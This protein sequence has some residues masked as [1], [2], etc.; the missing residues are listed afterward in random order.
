MKNNKK[1]LDPS[2]S[3]R[4]R[5]KA[6][7][8][9]MTLEEKISQMAHLAPAIPRLG[10]PAYTWWNECLHGVGRAGLATVF[11]QSIGM[12]ATFDA[13]LEKRVATAISDEAR[14]KFNEFQRKGYTG[15]YGGLT[16]WS[17]N[18]NIFRDPRWGRGQETLGED[19][20]LA[21]RMGVAF[22]KGLQGGDRRHLKA[23]ACAK[24]FAAHS[25]PEAG[26]NAFN[27]LVSQ[28]D[29]RETYLP[30]FKALVEEGGVE[31]VMTAYNRLNGHPCSANGELL[32]GILRDEWKFDGHVVSDCGAIENIY[33]HHKTA[34]SDHTAAA[35]AV[36]A[37]CDLCCGGAYSAL[38]EAVE[39]GEIEEGVI[40]RAAERLFLTRM[41]L[42]LFDPPEKSPWSKLGPADVCS[43]AHRRLALEAAEKSIVLLKND[44][45]LP[46][47]AR[48]LKSVAVCGPVAQDAA[49]LLG[50]YN[51]FA[52]EV[53][54]LLSGIVAAG[55]AGLHAVHMKGCEVAGGGAVQSGGLAWCFDP[56]EI[57]I[58]CV[59]YTPDLEGEEG[60]AFNADAGGDRRRIGLPA[61]QQELLEAL[62]TQ[63]KPV[64]AVVTG[65]SAIDLSWA[66]EHCAAVLMT[67]YG[68]E[69]GGEAAGRVL[70]GAANPA[71]RLPVTFPRTLDDVPDFSDYAMAGRTYRFSEAEPLF[72]FGYGLS[73]T[74]FRYS[75]LKLSK[76]TIAAGAPVTASV[77]V[78]NVGKL[79]GDEVAQLY[80]SHLDA[81]VPVPRLHLEG[82]ERVSRL[83]PGESRRIEF[84]LLPEQFAAYRDDGAPMIEPGRYAISIGGGQPGHAKTVSAEL[85]IK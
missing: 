80:I 79:E 2:L 29:L 38:L 85:R 83:R 27:T 46:L 59:G 69:A 30:A 67:W 1:H 84:T 34:C 60:D 62:C 41:R 37:G 28:R 5:A 8:A 66:R 7:V 15:M 70:F 65:G 52:R 18:I 33:N 75:A 20:H 77:T 81:T 47:D 48:R 3:F 25:G 44:G 50:N 53:T 54:T 26:R 22:V 63:G 23:A 73:Y 78:K 24:H 57:I 11:P 39:K 36:E 74:R 16:F 71:G 14:A 21:A 17:P 82:F 19:P 40:T 31:A 58:A 4:E 12:A 55:G 9:Q 68:G 32:Q 76:K 6:L 45:V 51:G 49:A 10:V 35:A 61:R 64:I 13:G 56:C 43:P 42:G 72:P